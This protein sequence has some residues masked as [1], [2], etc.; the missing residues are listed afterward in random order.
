[1]KKLVAT[2]LALSMALS[3]AA[4][5]GNSPASTAST[6]GSGSTAVTEAGETTYGLTPFAE[7]QTLRVGYFAGSAHAIPF[8]IAE[9]KGIFDELNIDIEYEPYTNGPAM[10][11]ASS[12]WDVATAGAA[13]DLVGMLGYDLICIGSTDYE[14]NMGLFVRADGPLADKKA[15]DWKGTTWLYPSGTNAQ[16][17]LGGELDKMGLTFDDIESVNMDIA[18]ALT[19]FKGGQ[20]DG[21]AVWNAI[22]TSAEDAGFV[23]VDDAGSLGITVFNG[24]MAT[25]EALA[26]RRDLVKTAWEVYYLTWQW[27]NE[28]DENMAEA[29]AY[30]LES[31]ENEGIACDEHIAEVVMSYCAIPTLSEAVSIMTETSPD[32]QG[33]Y[34]SRDL[35]QAEKD[36]LVTMDF[37]ISIG[38][39]TSDDRN[40]ILD[41]QMVDNSI[42]TECLADLDALGVQYN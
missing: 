3:L 29:V 4:C 28:S 13:G 21:I 14:T 36:L 30:Y 5:G 27:C 15:E 35:L 6:A 42:A 20:G 25:P 22:A 23:R 31:C 11:E 41:N 18:S 38:K 7:R 37:L 24:F 26:E 32:D 33:L 16:M 10:M 8:Y 19:A 9:Q 12:S 40:T 34:T 1:M 2:I 39:Y 17:V